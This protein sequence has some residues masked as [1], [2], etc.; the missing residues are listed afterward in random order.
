MTP[1]AAIG[2]G[3]AASLLLAPGPPPIA[4]RRTGLPRE[5][6]DG[7]DDYKVERIASDAAAPGAP[8][9]LPSGIPAAFATL[10]DPRGLR[11]LGTDGKLLCELWLRR[12]IELAAKPAAAMNVR[13]PRL[14]PGAF[15]GVLRASGATGDFRAQP[16][17]AGTYGLRYFHQPADGNHLGTSDSRD[18]LIITSFEHDRDPSPVPKQDDLM[19]L[20]T[21][22]SPSDHALVLY[23]ADLPAEDGDS[24]AADDAPRF[25]RRGEKEE[26]AVELSLAGRPPGAKE[27]E[28]VRFGLVLV[29]H[30]AE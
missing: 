26:W 4:E 28:S 8:P 23:V 10:V 29:G 1:L 3:L 16:I 19:A 20:S 18:F 30:V 5:D 17:D 12:E 7:S 2:A 6:A 15:L 27:V 25:Y 13:Q 21:P 24:P 9:A 11:L 14:P 22:V